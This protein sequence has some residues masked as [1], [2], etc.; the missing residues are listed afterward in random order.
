MADLNPAQV[1]DE[2]TPVDPAQDDTSQGDDIE[3]ESPD[4]KRDSIIKKLRDENAKR[5]VGNKE[6][7]EK[8]AAME[9]SIKEEANKKLIANQEFEKLAEQ[10]RLE[11]EKTLAEKTSLESQLQEYTLRFET[12]AAELMKAIKKKSIIK[13]LEGKTA[14]EKIAWIKEYNAENKTENGTVGKPT[15]SESKE[16]LVEKVLTPKEMDDLRQ[17]NPKLF[18]EVVALKIKK[19]KG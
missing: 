5:R 13:V 4:V 7:A 6:L 16:S 15:N 12:E 9:A 11:N 1:A 8:L 14:L 18:K 2:K 10:Y 17:T 19:L 3:F